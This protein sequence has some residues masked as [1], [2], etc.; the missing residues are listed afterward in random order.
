MLSARN[1]TNVIN[2]AIAYAA[3]KM[4][5]TVK[6]AITAKNVTSAANAVAVMKTAATV[7]NA[8]TATSAKNAVIANAVKKMVAKVQYAMTA[9]DA[10]IPHV[11]CPSAHAATN[12]VAEARSVR[13]AA[14]VAKCVKNTVRV[15]V[16]ENVKKAHVNAATES[17][18]HP[19][20]R[21]AA[22]NA[23]TADNATAA[24][25]TS[26]V[27]SSAANAEAVTNATRHVTVHKTMT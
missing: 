25:K 8:L 10:T 19:N 3:M 11:S 16:A 20:A 24:L 5:A 23:Q 4:A 22:E 17:V 13:N 7:K 6:N 12:P 9:E 21:E 15:Y 18:H 26:V 1:V 14:D 27:V 2:A